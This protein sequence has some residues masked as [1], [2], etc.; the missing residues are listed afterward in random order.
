MI[1]HRTQSMAV[2]KQLL[3]ELRDATKRLSKT[4]TIDQ[5]TLVLGV[6]EMLGDILSLTPPEGRQTLLNRA[7]HRII[8]TMQ[9]N[10]REARQ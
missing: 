1:D 10:Y 5:E 9:A 2:A 6:A 3:G 4:A 8:D 7:L